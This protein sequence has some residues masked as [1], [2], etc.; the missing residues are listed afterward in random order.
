M[1]RIIIRIT[2]IVFIVFIISFSID[3]IYRKIYRLNYELPQ[4]IFILPE[5]KDKYEIENYHKAGWIF[6]RF[7]TDN[8]ND[9]YKVLKKIDDNKYKAYPALY[10][11]SVPGFIMKKN[12]IIPNIFKFN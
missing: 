1:K 6:I 11:D 9:I 10:H 3:S 4:N 5:I 7:L 8:E 2:L 12:Q